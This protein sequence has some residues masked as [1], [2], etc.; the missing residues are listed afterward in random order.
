MLWPSR[1]YLNGDKKEIDVPATSGAVLE[2]D[3]LT[4][5][6]VGRLLLF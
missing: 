1:I 2:G 5:L 4:S 6:G 3:S